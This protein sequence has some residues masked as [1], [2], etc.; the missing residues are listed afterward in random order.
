MSGV[1]WHKADMPAAATDVRLSGAPLT[2]QS[3]PRA[4]RSAGSRRNRQPG[5]IDN[6]AARH[7]CGDVPPGRSYRLGPLNSPPKILK[8]GNQPG[9]FLN[10]LKQ[11]LFTTTH[12]RY[13][14]KLSGVQCMAIT[15]TAVMKIQCR[16]NTVRRKRMSQAHA[17]GGAAR[18]TNAEAERLASE[19][20]LR[21]AHSGR[22][23][24]CRS[25]G[26]KTQIIGTQ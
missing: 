6:S 13:L 23:S 12:K 7:S 17:E 4:N 26:C 25:P 5:Q 21:R 14:N 20:R 10:A 18:L 3:L 1:C 19:I 8:F 9:H 15:C 24:I 11:S 22:R 2:D 16:E